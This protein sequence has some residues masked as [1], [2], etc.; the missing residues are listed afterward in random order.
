MRECN[1]RR[2]THFP[3]ALRMPECSSR[4]HQSESLCI[5]PREK[6]GK[7]T[8]LARAHKV[9]ERRSERGGEREKA[10]AKPKGER[11]KLRDGREE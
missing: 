5:A 1:R 7:S 3:F 8:G 10:V 4:R 11:W 2:F 6:D 9:Q